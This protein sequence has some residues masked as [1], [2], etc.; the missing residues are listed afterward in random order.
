V[1]SKEGKGLEHFIT[2]A[3]EFTLFK[4]DYKKT[5]VF[6]LKYMYIN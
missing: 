3:W 4:R 5:A 1:N 2:E 6:I